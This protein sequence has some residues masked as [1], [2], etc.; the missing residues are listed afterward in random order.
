MQSC[1]RAGDFGCFGD[2][3]RR[4]EKAWEIPGEEDLRRWNT[5][6]DLYNIALVFSVGARANRFFVECSK[7]R[8]WVGR[9]LT[10]PRYISRAPPI[11]IGY[12]SQVRSY[13]EVALYAYRILT[14]P[15]MHATK[16]AP[17]RK[18]TMAFWRREIRSLKTVGRGRRKMRKSVRVF[19]IPAMRV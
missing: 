7:D 12:D 18:P 16:P 9:A 10:I 19:I 5:Y 8:K 1:P 13:V 6:A 11:H 3:I 14:A 17:N 15:A 2:G 4:A